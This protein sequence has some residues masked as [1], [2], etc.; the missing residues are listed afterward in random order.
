MGRYM[1]VLRTFLL[2]GAAFLFIGPAIGMCMGGSGDHSLAASHAHINLVGFV[3]S[4]IFALAYGTLSDM[5]ESRLSALHFW[6]HLVG[7]I[8]LNLT[9]FLLV[10]QRISEA[11]MTQAAPPAEAL[12]LV[13]ALLF[14]VN[15]WHNAR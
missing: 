3:L 10:S 6:F 4:S 12:V 13:G 8:G 2:L 5:G 9:L 7:A 11:A 1:D 15:A 14:L